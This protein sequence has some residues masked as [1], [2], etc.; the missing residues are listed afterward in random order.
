MEKHA[1]TTAPV[2]PAQLLALEGVDCRAYGSFGINGG[3][4]LDAFFLGD[5]E[6]LAVFF[7][8][9]KPWERTR[10]TLAHELGHFVLDHHFN[11][12]LDH[13]SQEQEAN[14]FAGELLCPRPLMYLADTRTVAEV[15][16]TFDVSEPCA[17]VVLQ[18]YKSFDP[19]RY[20]YFINMFRNQ[21]RHFIAAKKALQTKQNSRNLNRIL[22]YRELVF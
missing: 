15:C 18:L 7:D 4:K 17:K 21:F 6:H 5:R 16:E 8:E 14:R 13:E 12:L 11:N 1:I 19:E 22:G 10:F 20:K 3:P 9:A 2:A